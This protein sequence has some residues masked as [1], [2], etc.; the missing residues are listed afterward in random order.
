M[1]L[2]TAGLVALSLAIAVAAGPLFDLSERAA[3]DLLDPQ[4][5]I[6]AVLP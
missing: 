5:Y 1:L 2:A 6:R 4:S 3:T